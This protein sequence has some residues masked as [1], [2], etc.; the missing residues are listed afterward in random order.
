MSNHSWGG[1]ATDDILENNETHVQTG[2][3]FMGSYWTDHFAWI[4][5]CSL[6]CNWV[7]FGSISFQFA[8]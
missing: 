7:H 3:V 8:K 1:E 5:M 6:V 4:Q 2:F